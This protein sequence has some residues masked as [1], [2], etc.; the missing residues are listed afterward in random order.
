MPTF[1]AS[2]IELASFPEVNLGALRSIIASTIAELRDEADLGAYSTNGQFFQISDAA[3]S[4]MGGKLMGWMAPA[5]AGVAM[6]H[7]A[8]VEI[9][10]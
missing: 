10:L 7:S 4:N 3:K 5:S 6:R 1:V 2:R 9:C 8:G